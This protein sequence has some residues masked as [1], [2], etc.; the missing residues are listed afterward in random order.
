MFNIAKNL[1]DNVYQR[2]LASM[3]CKF[4]DKKSEGIGINTEVKPSKQFAKK[5]HKPKTLKKE[6]SVQDLKM[7]GVLI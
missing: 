5:L 1:K 6:Q 4:F 3:V 2:G 7:F